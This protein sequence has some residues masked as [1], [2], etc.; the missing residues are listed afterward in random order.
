[1]N[2]K[3]NFRNL[4]NIG[5]IAH[6][7]AGK[8]TTTERILFYTGENHR[9]GEVHDGATTMDF[10]PQERA[11]G[12]TI[13]SAATTV[14]W[15]GT[16]INLIDTPG[17]IDFNLEVRR[18]LRVL[19]AAVVVFD[20]VAGVEP[21]TETNWRLADEYRV[22]RLAFVNKLDRIGADFGRVVA[23]LEERLGVRALPLQLPIGAE[24]DFRGVVDLL[25]MQA[26]VWDRDDAKTP[27]R[28]DAIPPELLP[29]AQAARARLLEAAAEQ[30]DALL[31][32]WLRGAE[33]SQDE[34]RTALRRGTIAGAFV[35]VLAGSAF[36]NRG[37]EPLLD[38]VVAYLPAPGE[39]HGA[40]ATDGPLSAL[41]FKLTADDHGAMA[42]VRVYSGA[43][44]RGDTVFNA[45]TGKAERVSRL[46][47]IHADQR[48]ERDALVAGDIAGIVGLK[49]VLT[50]HTLA[51]RRDATVLESIAV[52]EAVIDVAIEARQHADTAA[53]AKGLGVLVREDPSLRLRQ[54][55]DSGQTLLS[56]MG[57]LQLEVAVEKLR[58]RF[59]VDVAVGR[60][61]VAYRET[62]TAAAEVRHVHKKQSGGPGQ[63]AELTL[64]IAPLPRGEGFRFQNGVV[65]GAI[66]REFIP[67]VE[68]GIRKASQAG[69]F[70]GYP[71][72][73]F[74]A[75][76]VDGSAHVRDSSALAFELA[77]ATALREA[78]LKAAPVALE[79]VMA[80]E[81]ITPAD[82]VGDVIGDLLR[83]R[84]H[85]Q[86]QDSRGN[87]VVVTA[88]VPLERM[89]GYIGQLRALSSG[90]AQ[91]TMQLDH[92]AAVPARAALAA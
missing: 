89:F 77:A 20:G 7:D 25:A 22:P 38:A 55:A 44:K 34:L 71:L 4:R 11:R 53:L 65:G 45:S 36:R 17:H 19:D 47:E 12:I 54:D 9:I 42:F 14:H 69:P 87:A 75:T 52:P 18:S 66:P 10:D 81:V 5:V 67:A 27:P 91:F 63:F 70:A 88:H 43:L 79:P 57:E 68:A 23:S 26:L 80:V 60:P 41:A 82:H 86:G 28:M 3:S 50:G 92:Y 40:V 84:G 37:V 21:Q 15:H 90:R 16:Q 39:A 78:V 46:Y 73:D 48:V 2:S 74:E 30:D 24:G 8:T 85:V 61:Q 6:V 72:V 35:P 31:D 58:S 62:I 29:A 49:D 59:G 64:R 56:G 32:G 13:H 51:D 33:P 83:R 1:M 76:L